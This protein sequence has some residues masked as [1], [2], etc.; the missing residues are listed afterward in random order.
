ML[1][2][3]TQD[4]ANQLIL[5]LNRSVDHVLRHRWAKSRSSLLLN[6]LCI[7]RLISRGLLGSFRNRSHSS[8]TGRGRWRWQSVAVDYRLSPEVRRSPT[9][10]SALMRRPIRAGMFFPRTNPVKMN[11][12]SGG[13][14]NGALER[15]VWHGRACA[16]LRSRRSPR[17]R[18]GSPIGYA[19][20]IT[21]SRHGVP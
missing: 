16:T 5:I 18:R 3:A 2:L 9:S 10:K 8:S 4:S 15:P 11:I 14:P 1:A 19:L 12:N 6:P 21:Q 7:S 17:S 20:R 13:K